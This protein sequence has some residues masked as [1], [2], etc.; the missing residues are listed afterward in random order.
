MRIV[1]EA[2]H[3]CFGDQSYAVRHGAIVC[4]TAAVVG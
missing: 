4:T 2:A 3:S 1:Y